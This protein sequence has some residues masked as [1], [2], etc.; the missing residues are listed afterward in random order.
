MQALVLFVN[1]FCKY[2]IYYVNIKQITFN[3]TNLKSK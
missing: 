1:M 2:K 3:K